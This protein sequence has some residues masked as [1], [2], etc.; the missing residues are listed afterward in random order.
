MYPPQKAGITDTSLASPIGIAQYIC[1]TK[2]VWSL[3]WN[4]QCLWSCCTFLKWR[5]LYYNHWY[6]TCLFHTY[7]MKRHLS[8]RGQSLDSLSGVRPRDPDTPESRL[9]Q[10]LRLI[11]GVIPLFLSG[12]TEG[13]PF[14]GD[15]Y[16]SESWLQRKSC[17]I[18]T[19]PLL[20]IALF[21][22]WRTVTSPI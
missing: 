21:E 20:L 1:F 4:T 6:V 13:C 18:S 3:S 5:A 17:S 8:N 12:K 15:A 7:H 19:L 14:H 9:W 11:C 10:Y 16:W 2:S 22:A